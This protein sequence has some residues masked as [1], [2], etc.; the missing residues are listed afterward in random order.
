MFTLVALAAVA[1]WLPIHMLAD[2]AG[3]RCQDVRCGR[4]LLLHIAH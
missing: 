3:K 1:L 4:N 2:R